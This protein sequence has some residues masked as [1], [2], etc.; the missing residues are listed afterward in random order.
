MSGESDNTEEVKLYPAWRQLEADILASGV[1]DGETIS[2]DYMRS[3]LGLRD[4]RELMGEEALREQAQFNFAM[5]EL[6]DSLTTNH[7][8]VLRLVPGVG[9]MV[10]PPQDQT[11][12]ALKDHGSEVFNALSRAV[13]KVTHI[14]TDALTDEQLRENADAQAKLATLTAIA[15]K[16]LLTSDGA[17]A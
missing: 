2:M 15:R 16:R 13:Q 8:I 17:K 1:K 3:A 6:K 7:R 14:R 5:G 10:T 9:Y 12:L 11:R 4:P